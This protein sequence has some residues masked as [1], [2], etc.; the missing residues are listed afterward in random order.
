VPENC[1]LVSIYRVSIDGLIHLWFT[2]IGVDTIFLN[3]SRTFDVAMTDASLVRPALAW[4]PVLLLIGYYPALLVYRLFFSPMS[5]I[6]GPWLTRISDV[7]EAN[8]LKDKRR[9]EWASDLFKQYPE[10]VAVRTRPNAVSFNHPDAVKAI[11][12]KLRS[13]GQVSSN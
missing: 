5:K 9:A 2:S 3:I 10:S 1:R 6:P 7:P 11:Y 4:A 8:A 13:L 12:G